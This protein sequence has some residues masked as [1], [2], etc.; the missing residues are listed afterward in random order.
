MADSLQDLLD[1]S[2]ETMMVHRF[3]QFDDT[4]MA[5]TFVYSFFTLFAL[6][7]AVDSTKM[8]IIGALCAWSYA[9]LVPN[10]K[11]EIGFDEIMRYSTYIVS[12]YTMSITDRRSLSWGEKTPNLISSTV[13]TLALE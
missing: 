6:D 2:H 11:S 8:R 10:E 13:R 9:L 1:F 5:R 3:G 12:G 7:A 4:K